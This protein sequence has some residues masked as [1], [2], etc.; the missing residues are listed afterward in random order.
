M[1]AS[2]SASPAPASKQK[3]CCDKPDH[4]TDDGIYVCRNCRSVI[5]DSYFVEEVSFGE[6]A[7]GAAVVHGTAVTQN[8]WYNKATAGAFRYGARSSE[9]T[10]QANMRTAKEEMT[11]LASSLY[12]SS[13][14]TRALHLYSIMRIHHFHRPLLE[15]IAIC[16]YIVCRQTKGNMTLLIDFAER[17]HENVFDLGAV[18]KQFIRATSID[19]EL[20]AMPAVEIEPLLYK[21]AKRLEFGT[22]TRRVANDAASILARMDRDWIVTGRQPAALCGAALILAA[23]MN[24]FRR[25][26]RELVYVVKAADTTIL[27]R[28]AEFRRTKAGQLTVASFR[29]F[30]RLLRDR[31]EPPSVRA[32]RER[33]ILKRKA[34]EILDDD[35]DDDEQPRIDQDGFAI[36]ETPKRPGR[37]STSSAESSPEG[38][39]RKKKRFVPSSVVLTEEDIA[40]ENQ[41]EA[42]IV[43]VVERLGVEERFQMTEARAK[44]LAEAE[45]A[46]RRG[47][48]SSKVADGKD[49]AEDEFADDPE[50]TNCLLSQEEVDVKE[51]IWVTHNH[52][53]LRREQERLLDKAMDEALGKTKRKKR[54][55]RRRGD[56][57]DGEEG[58]ESESPAS[59]PA[60]ASQRM[61]Q[62][63]NVRPA[64][65][66]HI[67]YEKLQAI[68]RVGDGREESGDPS[69]RAGSVLEDEPQKTPPVE[70]EEDV[71]EEEEVEEEEIEAEEAE[72]SDAELGTEYPEF[73]EAYDD[74]EEVARSDDERD[75]EY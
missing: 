73:Q 2:A 55:K 3:A 18:Y 53:W 56:Q 15:S 39:K 47:G 35:D 29:Q 58:A 72:E 5:S 17:I 63:R 43:Q 61:L 32:A 20:E 33:A 52:D 37:P 8:Q 45:Q 38:P 31:E 23:R 40:E 50:V 26:V 69:T 74:D 9:E 21:Y 4:M 68:Y 19:K 36:P 41:L 22:S 64:F 59:T 70:E 28:L 27:K 1:S 65:S 24:N 75:Y 71:E 48:G 57:A 46:R 44:A 67:N 34:V 62:R 7:A 11:R 49:I 54:V 13:A 10:H 6:N 14:V 25:S 30:S 60:E 12:I 16:L 42:E 51:K 66:R